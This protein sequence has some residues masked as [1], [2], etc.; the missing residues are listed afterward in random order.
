MDSSLNLNGARVVKSE[1]RHQEESNLNWTFA[2]PKQPVYDS[3]LEI[4][5]STLSRLPAVVM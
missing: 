1:V 4:R 2:V 5:S 3:I